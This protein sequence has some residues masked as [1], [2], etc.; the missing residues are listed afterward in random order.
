VVGNNAEEFFG[1]S[2]GKAKEVIDQVVSDV[3]EGATNA[4]SFFGIDFRTPAPVKPPVEAP[5]P[6]PKPLENDPDGFWAAQKQKNQ[7]EAPQRQL[8]ISAMKQKEWGDELPATVA[9]LE[10][11][12]ATKG[13]D[14]T[15]RRILRTEYKDLTGK[16]HN[17]RQ[18]P[19]SALDV[20]PL[21]A[22]ELKTPR[23]LEAAGKFAQAAGD[24]ILDVASNAGLGVNASAA[25]ATAGEMVADPLN[26]ISGAKGVAAV[27]AI[28][29]KDFLKLFPKFS[30]SVIKEGEDLTPVYH[31]TQVH[32]RFP[33]TSILEFKTPTGANVQMREGS[34]VSRIYPGDL[35][36]W[37][38]SSPKAANIFAGAGD[39]RMFGMGAPKGEVTQGAAVYE[40]YV[41]LQN[42][43]TF[44]TYNQFLDWVFTIENQGKSANYARRSLIKEGHDGIL[45]KSSF[46]DGGG[47]RS[48]MVVFNPKDI[49]AATGASKLEKKGK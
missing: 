26:F 20:K 45:I 18:S 49:E 11:A 41:N 42:P 8:E 7:L 38:A 27:G 22:T 40:S 6:L 4:L 36:T 37:F 14:G 5:R 29:S 9:T 24:K 21:A 31:G 17:S 33:D 15:V 12:L 39:H 32:K 34:D 44:D 19:R 30:K 16:D 47:S 2:F 25:L 48:D 10:K 23:V 1:Q 28:A 46:T 43:K 35:G 3:K 13:M